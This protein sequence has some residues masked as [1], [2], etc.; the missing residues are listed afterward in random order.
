VP[1]AIAEILRAAPLSD[2]KVTFAWSA[3]VGP[4]LERVTR[5]KL[6]QHVLIVETASPQWSREIMRSSAIILKRLQAFLGAG[7]VEKIEVRRA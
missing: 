7:V 3:A 4:A 1:G 5:V 2:G 6:E